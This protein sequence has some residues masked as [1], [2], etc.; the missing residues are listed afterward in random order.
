MFVDRGY[1]GPIDGNFKSLLALI[2]R[3]PSRDDPDVRHLEGLYDGYIRYADSILEELVDP[4]TTW[5][6][7]D[8]PLVI[9]T[10]DHG[11]AFFE[12]GAQGHNR[13]IH[14]EMIHVPLVFWLPGSE[15]PGGRVLDTPVSLLDVLPTLQDLF[16][17]DETRQYQ[18][19]DSLASLLTSTSG[20]TFMPTRPLFFTSRHSDNYDSMWRGVRVAEHK[21]IRRSFLKSRD[22][23]DQ[24]YNLSEDPFERNDLAAQYPMRVMALRGVLDRWWN[25]VSLEGFKRDR[26]KLDAAHRKAIEAI[27]YAGEDG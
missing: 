14:E 25:E 17:L 2:K 8:S 22:V 10:S 11:E 24:L 16:E 20:D 1:E 6:T 12:H 26:I 4:I 13:N 7:A 18:Q 9:V 5:A 21:L 15:W 23:V 3:N 27:G 19:G